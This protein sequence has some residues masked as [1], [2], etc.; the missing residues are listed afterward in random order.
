M[1]FL[2]AALLVSYEVTPWKPRGKAYDFYD[3]K[4]VLDQ[5][6]FQCGLQVGF[7]ANSDK[8]FLF[9]GKSVNCCFGKEIFGYMGELLPE[10]TG[11]IE[12][13]FVLEIDLQI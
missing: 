5:L 12:K 10:K 1:M 2:T 13:V 4:G 6:C 3:L 11:V 8:P 7:S 9:P